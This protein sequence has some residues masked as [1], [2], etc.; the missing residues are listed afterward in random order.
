MTG[1]AAL[2]TA[3]ALLAAIVARRGIVRLGA[4]S[5]VGEHLQRL[6]T[7]IALLLALRLLLFVWP[8]GF[9]VSL[10]MVVAAWLPLATLRLSEE[11]VRRHA[12]RPLK[13]LALSG[14]V[15]FSVLAITFG[16]IWAR[17]AILALAVYQSVTIGGVLFHLFAQRG[18]VPAAERAAGDVLA[19]A[20]IVTV[21]LLATDFQWLFPDLPFRGG[22]FA[23][24]VFVLACSHLIGGSTRPLSLITDCAVALGAGAIAAVSAHL[25]KAPPD[26]S[27]A[28]AACAT[29]SAALLLLIE[30]FSAA[31]KPESDLLS[32]IAKADSSI[33]GILSSHPL[34]SSAT[35]I[36]ARMV[37]DLPD[38][39]VE[40]LGRHRVLFIDTL[41]TEGA[42]DAAARELLGRYSATHLLRVSRDPV[43]FLALSGGALA[44]SQLSRDLEIV[45]RLLDDAE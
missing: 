3:I 18:T 29:A 36:D 8:V 5:G 27:F 6:L 23:A 44:G 30:R 16:L 33:A 37:P 21:P 1:F 22:P 24:L 26:L 7:L 2:L 42:P 41:Q 34:L 19:L 32:E 31:R 35:R 28:I 14:A 20:F 4:R 38:D 40:T 10:V 25:L 15:G 9:V 43:Q 12:P 17:E 45:G 39:T 13:L 11:L